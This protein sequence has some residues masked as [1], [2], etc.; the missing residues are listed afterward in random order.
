VGA[1]VAFGGSL[2]TA[3]VVST[4]G[5][6]SLGYDVTFQWNTIKWGVN[7]S[8]YDP[9]L[10]F[11]NVCKEGGQGL[12]AMAFFAFIGLLASLVLSICRLCK[13]MDLVPLQFQRLHAYFNFQ[14]LLGVLTTIFFFLISVIWGATCWTESANL[15][16]AQDT[17]V[18]SVTLVATGF[19]YLIFCTVVMGI[20][21]AC[22][23]ILRKFEVED[24]ETASLLS[25]ASIGP[26]SGSVSFPVAA[27][28][29]P[30][31]DEG[32]DP[33]NASPPI[34]NVFPSA[35]QHQEQL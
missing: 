26:S 35:V 19:A 8:P 21:S 2:H 1:C 15:I 9:T 25:S 34:K 18:T 30:S 5:E 22:W 33:N 23:G 13:R 29:V 12:L 3:H 32:P 16:K 10:P 6:L 11:G 31:G 14:L 17:T 7:V 24:T 27:P 20:T 4:N 28:V